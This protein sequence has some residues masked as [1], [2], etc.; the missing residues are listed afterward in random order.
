VTEQIK[1]AEQPIIAVVGPTASGKSDLAIEI[2][3]R[4][5]GEIIN[6]DSVQVYSGLYIGTAKVPPEERRGVPHHL[7]DVVEPDAH[8]TAGDYSVRAS[9]LI[10]DIEARRKLAVLAGGTGFYLRALCAPLFES[11]PTDL[12]LRDRLGRIHARRGPAHIHRLLTRV[13]PVIAVRVPVNDWSRAIRALEFYFQTGQPISQHLMRRPSSPSFSSRL[14]MVA[15]SPPRVAL[16]ERI[17]ERTDRMFRQ[18]WVE[19][20]QGL[21]DAGVPPSAKVFGAHGYRRI[22][23][24]LRGK[25]GLEGAIELTRQDVRHYAK[26]QLTWFRREPQVAWFEGFGDDPSIQARV[27][28]H[29]LSLFPIRC[30]KLIARQ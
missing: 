24:Y 21:L 28:E 11:P 30:G 5:D 10:W 4:F 19:E 18:G 9:E 20:V 22:L 1:S 23:Q 8:F 17:N 29:V 26:R 15:L 3:L 6:C 12:G 2:A 16:Y 25:V 27:M 13:D 14:H 7:I